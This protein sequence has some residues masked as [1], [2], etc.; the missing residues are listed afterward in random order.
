MFTRELLRYLNAHP[1]ATDTV[2]GITDWW[3][4]QVHAPAGTREVQAAL[5]Y[6]VKKGWITE[7]SLPSPKFYG[8]NKARIAELSAFLASLEKP[9]DECG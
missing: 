5:D 8:L 4:T 9:S 6:L 3:L 2:Q 7:K 1:D